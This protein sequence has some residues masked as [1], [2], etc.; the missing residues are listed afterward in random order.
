MIQ[1]KEL[2]KHYGDT[3]AVDAL[4]F[5]VAPG[6][7]TGFL[8][9]NGA[10]KSTTMRM[11]LGL[12]HPNAGSATIGG[13]NHRNLPAP[14][15]EVGSLLN[16]KAVHPARAARAHLRWLARAGGLPRSRID[17]VLELVGLAEVANKRV[18]GFSLGMYQRLGI[19]AALLGQPATLLLDE[20]VNGLD[21]EGVRWMRNL[22]RGL[23]AEGRTVFV[24]SHL[25]AEMQQTADRVVVIGRGRLIADVDVAELI[26]C[27]AD[28][29]VKVVSPDP[30]V[31]TTLLTGE[32]ATV[33]SDSDGGLLVSGM[34]SARVG[35]IA[36][37]LLSPFSS[38]TREAPSRRYW[39]SCPYRRS[40][41]RYRRDGNGF[42]CPGGPPRR[43]T[44]SPV[45]PPRIPSNI[46]H[47]A[48]PLPYSPGGQRCFFWSLTPRSP[49][50]TPERTRVGGQFL[51]KLTTHPFSRTATARLVGNPPCVAPDAP[52]RPHSRAVGIPVGCDPRESASGRTLRCSNGPVLTLGSAAWSRF[53]RSLGRG[54][55]R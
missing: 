31:L 14:M 46:S 52:E 21:P 10:G 25:M 41:G 3:V 15:R 9:P 38:G 20:P 11:I 34:D 7:V 51:E 40:S 16:P 6:V 36:T 54:V 1:V 35:D 2:S 42:S 32:G 55:S 45:R 39:P 53:L 12:D 33:R 49:S 22:M 48:G 17:E 24:S 44:A 13:R 26:R 30:T 28:D 8:G 23:A 47:R 19:A 43:C 5:D 18:S 50:E 29:Q 27:S 4:S 37:V